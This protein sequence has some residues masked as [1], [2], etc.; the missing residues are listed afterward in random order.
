MTVDWRRVVG[1]VSGGHFL[2]HFYLLALPPL[3]PALRGDLGLT[4]TQ[5]GLVMSALSV[6]SLLQLPV[7][8][9]VDRIGAKRVFV[10]GT[11]VTASGI[12][13]AGLVLASYPALLAAALLSGVG[14]SAFHPADYALLGAATPGEAEGRSFGVHT[15][16]GY[17]GFAAAPLV[18]G[19]VTAVAGPGVALGAVGLVGV[20]YAAVAA[21]AL[22][23]VY[24]GTAD[25]AADGDDDPESAADPAADGGAT[26]DGGRASLREELLRR[27]VL[28]LGVFFLVFGTANKAA[29][30]FTTV[31]ATDAYGLTTSAGNTALTAFFAASAVG[32]LVGGVVADR[33]EPRRVAVVTL[34]LAS[35]ALVAVVYGV[36]PAGPT[37]AVAGFAAVGLLLGV[38]YPSRDRLVSRGTSE[39]S[40]GRGFGFAFSAGAVGSVGGP[41]LLGAVV[42]AVDARAAFLLAGALYLVTAGVVLLV[43][44]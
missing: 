36:A 35:V 27:D 30:T 21:L 4:N 16:G 9:L 13:V 18:V 23:A 25:G 41:V 10:V 20:A 8:E 26:G 34:A 40:T 38:V 28:A 15:F 29:Q 2:S 17:A 22:P 24:R 43:R 42:D 32:I 12:A 44:E 11:A 6:G 19:G 14:Q 31:L 5:L 37:A 39:G 7:G 33:H 3:F 1:L